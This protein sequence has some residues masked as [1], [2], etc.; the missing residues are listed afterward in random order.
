MM[1]I[2]RALSLLLFVCA[3]FAAGASAQLTVLHN[4]SGTDGA[5]PTG[6]VK[7]GS[8]FYGAAG[9]GGDVTSCPSDGCGLVFK[10]DA[11]GR[12]TILHVFHSECS[13]TAHQF[14]A[15]ATGQLSFDARKR[16][17]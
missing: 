4:F 2:P 7:I 9:N 11:T 12:F 8:F 13:R 1:R 17:I 16:K 10:M 14:P 5:S 6:L 3:A 15:M